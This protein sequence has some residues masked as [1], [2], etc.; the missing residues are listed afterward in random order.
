MGFIVMSPYMHIKYF[1]QIYSPPPL[2]IILF[3]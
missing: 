2:F 3:S 1:D